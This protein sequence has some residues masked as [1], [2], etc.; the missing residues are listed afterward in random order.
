VSVARRPDVAKLLSLSLIL[1]F[2]V[3]EFRWKHTSSRKVLC[4]ASAANASATHSG[5]APMHSGALL[6]VS[7]TSQWIAVS[8][9]SS[10]SAAVVEGTTQPITGAVWNGNRP[11]RRLLGLHL[12]CAVRV[13]V[14]LSLPLR[15]RIEQSRPTGRR[16]WELVGTTSVGA[17]F[18]G[19]PQPNPFPLPT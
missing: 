7:L 15:R 17:A 1:T 6:V 18:S 10:W 14:R 5:V 13:A 11:R 2:A 8:G 9:T 16:T 12:L 19:L 3:C 4:S